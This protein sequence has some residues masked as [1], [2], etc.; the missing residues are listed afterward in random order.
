MGSRYIRTLLVE[1]R[2][3][4]DDASV[5]DFNFFNWLPGAKNP[6]SELDV[7]NVAIAN[8]RSV[9][10]KSLNL[11]ALGRTEFDVLDFD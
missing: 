1:Q 6:S 2:V 3:P 11:A 5:V 8:A 4:E 10:C 7:V 9:N